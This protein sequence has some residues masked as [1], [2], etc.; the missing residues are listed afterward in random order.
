MAE[1][2]VEARRAKLALLRESG[3][4]PYPD[5]WHRTHSLADARVQP[6]GTDGVSVAGRVLAK[7]EI[8]RKLVFLTL[9]VDAISL[10]R[11]R[12]RTS[13]VGEGMGPMYEPSSWRVNRA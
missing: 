5:R 9:P 6:D 10:T 3:R 11:E 7:R 13:R 12:C 2:Q 8:S 1:D 4:N